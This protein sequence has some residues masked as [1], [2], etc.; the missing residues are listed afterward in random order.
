MLIDSGSGACAQVVGAQAS[1]AAATLSKQP[2]QTY[3]STPDSN[4]NLYANV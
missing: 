1:L 3:Y 2:L 4:A